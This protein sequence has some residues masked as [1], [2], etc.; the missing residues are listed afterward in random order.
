MGNAF[1][2]LDILPPSHKSQNRGSSCIS[3]V[4]QGLKEWQLRTARSDRSRHMIETW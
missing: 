2:A 3:R 1:P 4:R